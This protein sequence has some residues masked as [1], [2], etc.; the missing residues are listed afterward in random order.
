MLPFL[1]VPPVPN[2]TSATLSGG[3]VAFLYWMGYLNGRFV[4]LHRFLS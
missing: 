3:G 1:S 4:S 2:A